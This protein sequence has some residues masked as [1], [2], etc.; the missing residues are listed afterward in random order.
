MFEEKKQRAKYSFQQ[1][2]ALP[3]RK[4][5][6][7]LFLIHLCALCDLCGEQLQSLSIENLINMYNPEISIIGAAALALEKIFKVHM[8]QS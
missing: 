5:Y 6:L 1:P 3:L 4:T 8:I 7:L 2:N